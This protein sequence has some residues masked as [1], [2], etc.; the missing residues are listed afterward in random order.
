MLTL[1]IEMIAA[2]VASNVPVTLK[3]NPNDKRGLVETAEFL[4]RLSAEVTLNT[5]E[6][7]VC[8]VP[9][10]R[11]PWHEPIHDIPVT[12]PDLL[13]LF[14]GVVVKMNLMAGFRPLF[15][16]DREELAAVQAVF[17]KRSSIFWHDGEFCVVSFAQNMPM[18]LK[19]VKSV[20]VPFAAGVLLGSVLGLGWTE[21]HFGA[22]YGTKKA[23]KT[24]HAALQRFSGPGVNVGK[25]YWSNVAVRPHTRLDFGYFDGERIVT[26]EDRQHNHQVYWEWVAEIGRAH[27]RYVAWFLREKKRK[28]EAKIRRN[29]EEKKRRA[30]EGYLAELAR[31]REA[32]AR[33]A[34]AGERV[35]TDTEDES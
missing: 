34:A 35:Q 21:I 29:R 24:A 22:Y 10:A 15:A 7:T 14:V 32:A 23:I 16:P 12:F 33:A 6:R 28:H 18:K 31:E 25:M 19:P 9:L 3:Y 26:E 4:R 11:V 1:A 27:K 5:R 13:W 8:I 20:P 30:R 17:P 2:A